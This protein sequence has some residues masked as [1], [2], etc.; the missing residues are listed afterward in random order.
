MEESSISI[1]FTDPLNF[2]PLFPHLI[3]SF[4]NFF[5]LLPK[6]SFLLL[7]FCSYSKLFQF[8]QS[9]SDF[10]DLT[11][12]A[13]KFGLPP[14]RETQ[15]ALIR[16]FKEI[17]VPVP[18]FRDDSC[19]IGMACPHRLK[20]EGFFALTMG[21]AA[22]IEDDVEWIMVG[23]YALEVLDDGCSKNRLPRRRGE[24]SIKSGT[25]GMRMGSSVPSSISMER[26]MRFFSK[27]HGPPSKTRF[28]SNS[29]L[30]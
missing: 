18:I 26:T 21:I 3:L 1:P 6:I 19:T 7:S 17:A 9:V 10:L 28:F 24:A 8:T 29:R 12:D 4:K 25:N 13:P 2:L 20:F 5:H 22:T 11:I 23:V 27:D 30:N 14:N 16:R 15:S